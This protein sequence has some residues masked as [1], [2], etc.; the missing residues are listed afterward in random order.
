LFCIITNQKSKL[1]FFKLAVV[2]L[3]PT[4]MHLAFFNQNIVKEEQVDIQFKGLA[5]AKVC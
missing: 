4:I 5:T 1:F 2:Q 3:G